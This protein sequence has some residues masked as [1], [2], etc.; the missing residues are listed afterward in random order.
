MSEREKRGN[1]YRKGRLAF[2]DG[3]PL[4]SNPM[5]ARDS[6]LFWV[7]GWHAEQNL[8]RLDDEAVERR[9]IEEKR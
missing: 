2:L 4:G 5:R 8:K 9:K 7:N 1:A 6:R 3:R